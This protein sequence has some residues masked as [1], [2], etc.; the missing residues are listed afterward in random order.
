MLDTV[1]DVR[2]AARGISKRRGFAVA[3]IVAVGIGIAAVTSVFGLMN[4]MLWQAPKGVKEPSRLM[5]LYLDE[6]AT[7]EIDY[8][9]LSYPQYEV[10]RDRQ[11]FFSDLILNYRFPL[12]VI[13]SEKR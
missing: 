13:M 6:K 7:P 9:G 10:L 12:I 11:D 1:Q 5:A 2:Y 8:R 4:T 3:T